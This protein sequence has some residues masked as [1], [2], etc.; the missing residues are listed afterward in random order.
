MGASP[1]LRHLAARQPARRAVRLGFPLA[2]VASAAWLAGAGV[3]AVAAERA[4]AAASAPA[5]TVPGTVVANARRREWMTDPLEMF[6][7]YSARGLINPGLALESSHP[8]STAV[9]QPITTRGMDPL[10]RRLL[11]SAF[12]L[13]LRHLSGSPACRAL[14]EELGTDGLLVLSTTI[15]FS[16]ATKETRGL[17]DTLRAIAYT[18]VGQQTTIVCPAFARLSRERAAATL[19]HEGLHYAGLTE[20]PADPAARSSLEISRLVNDRCDL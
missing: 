17:C 12:P 8:G 4:A 5:A 13:A 9:V 6:R 7:L 20:R 3:D 16:P 14:Y 1:V 10:A 11:V 2:L 18:R 15:Y 19:L